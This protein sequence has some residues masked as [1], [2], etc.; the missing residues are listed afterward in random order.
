MLHTT[1]LQ[2]PLCANAPTRNTMSPANNACVHTTQ[3]PEHA[4]PGMAHAWNFRAML[5]YDHLGQPIF[6]HKTVRAARIASAAAAQAV[7][8]AV[9]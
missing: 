7:C 3:P 4:T 2:L 1:S 9:T 5:Q 6:L 8:V